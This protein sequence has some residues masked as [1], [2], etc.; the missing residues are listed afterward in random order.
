[1]E[2]VKFLKK[3]EFND[4]LEDSL[5]KLEEK[6]SSFITKNSLNVCCEGLYSNINPTPE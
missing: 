6:Y 4:E 1:M 3:L 2:T 5:K